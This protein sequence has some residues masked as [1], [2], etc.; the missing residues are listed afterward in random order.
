MLINRIEDVNTGVVSSEFNVN[1]P[2]NRYAELYNLVEEL[3]EN[4]VKNFPFYE[5]TQPVS[6]NTLELVINRTW[7][8]QLTV[9][10]FDGLPENKDAGNVSNPWV[11]AKL[12]MRVPPTL[13]A[14]LKAQQFKKMLEENPPY[15]ASVSVPE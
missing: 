2:A 11:A 4:A 3:G 8:P 13:N 10:G 5:N 6:K 7:K 14:A 9:I 1:I 15:K 12:S